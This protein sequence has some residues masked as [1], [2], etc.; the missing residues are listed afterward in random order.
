MAQ[1]QAV[2][3]YREGDADPD[4]L[5]GQVIAVVGYGNLGRSMALN[6]R[7]SGLTVTVGN[8]DDPYRA[9]AL[10]DRFDVTGI[11]EAVAAADL[12]YVL[13]PDEVIPEVFATQ[14]GPSLRPGTCVCF[15]SGYVLA[16]G[17]VEPPQGVDVL[18]LAPR[19]LG[20]EVRRTYLEARGFL[21]YVSVEQ[22]A[23]GKARDRLLGLARAAGSLRRGAL[24][25]TAAQEALLDLFVE[26]AFGAYL[27]VAMQSA[28]QV[29]TQAGLP[30]EAMVVELYMSGEMSRTLQAFADNGFFRSVT[31]HGL[32]AAFGGFLRTTE[33]DMEA[34]QRHF[35]KILE[36]IR[37]GGFAQRF[38]QEQ[39]GGYPTLSAIEAITS[40]EDAMTRA[41]ERVRSSLADDRTFA[42]EQG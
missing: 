36:D 27:G 31:W 18:L 8:A 35:R 21:S 1:Q 37:S 40:G 7:D 20:E 17:L 11:A 34:M 4:A 33:I 32:S 12:V 38:Q 42:S 41:E 25:L 13:V 9:T 23:T 29:G 14:I 28:F 6:L 24:G 16:F 26:Q 30:A 19:M 10:A 22:D 5:S 3:F 2:T 15:A 39:A